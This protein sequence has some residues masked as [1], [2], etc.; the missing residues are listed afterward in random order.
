[1]T[2]RSVRPSEIKPGKGK[3]LGQIGAIEFGQ[4]KN[5]RLERG[6]PWDLRSMGRDC[7]PMANLLGIDV[8]AGTLNLTRI[9]RYERRT[10]DLV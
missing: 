8:V 3:F 4:Y 9:C 7:Q 5:G 6:G 10:H 2:C 1:L